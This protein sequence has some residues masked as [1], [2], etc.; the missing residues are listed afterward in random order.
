[1]FHLT[2]TVLS[3]VTTLSF[4]YMF[5]IAMKRDAHIRALFLFCFYFVSAIVTVGFYN[6]F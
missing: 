1:M 5:F 6:T 4:A 2:I 3:T